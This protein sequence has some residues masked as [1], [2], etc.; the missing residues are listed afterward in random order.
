MNAQIKPDL[1]IKT[2]VDGNFHS[3]R[4][5]RTVRVH[6]KSDT[7]GFWVCSDFIT[8]QALVIHEAK[9]IQSLKD[10]NNG[11]TPP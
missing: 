8:G 9:L 6:H 11:D 7:K 10:Q 4:L 1:I 3:P 5:T 2:E